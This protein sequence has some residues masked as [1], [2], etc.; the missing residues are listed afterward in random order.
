MILK[1]TK[2]TRPGALRARAEKLA[3][4]KK[5]PAGM[6]GAIDTTKALHELQVHQI[7]LE[8]QNE[9]LTTAKLEIEKTRNKYIFMYDFAPVGYLTLDETGLVRE[10]NLTVCTLLGVPRKELL[11]KRIQLYLPMSARENFN[12][13]LNDCFTSRITHTWELAFAPAGSAPQQ[14]QI[15]GIA[16]NDAG[17]GRH[18]LAAITDVTEQNLAHAI[19]ERDNRALEDLVEVKASEV[20][21]AQDDLHKAKRLAD[22]GML[23]ATVAHELRNPLTAINIAASNIKRKAPPAILD[24]HIATIEKKVVESNQIINNLLFYARLK[25]P[26]YER[27]DLHAILTECIDAIRERF[28]GKN[29]MI[30][31]DYEALSR[32]PCRADPLQM[33]ELFMN[34]LNNAADAVSVETGTIEIE[35]TVD[36]KNIDIWINDNGSGIHS[37]I[38]DKVYDPFFTTKAKGTGLGLAVCKQ[39]VLLHNGEIE[40]KSDPGKGTRVHIHF[41]RA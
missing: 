33:K 10:A 38:M 36:G 11:K 5:L 12:A 28:A 27:T 25:Y 9:E 32:I 37:E 2:P 23:A 8:M 21:V 16:V 15:K 41:L 24:R 31:K 3:R 6:S 7:E 18:T 4:N 13:F 29:V 17:N 22:I 20:L 30:E 40:I 1:H 35:G 26:H 39:I 14:L 19:L 34:V